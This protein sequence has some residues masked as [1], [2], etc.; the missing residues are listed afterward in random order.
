MSEE[1]LLE[2]GANVNA[3]DKKRNYCLGVAMDRGFD[4]IVEF[5]HEKVL[6]NCILKH[7]S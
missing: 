7:S 1:F 2:C 4:E 5:L 6:G 3:K